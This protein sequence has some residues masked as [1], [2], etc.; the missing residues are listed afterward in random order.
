MREVIR[1][2]LGV[3]YG[4]PTIDGY[5]GG[6]LPLKS[7]ADFKTLLIGSEP[8]VPH[9]TLA[10]QAPARPNAPLLAAL[11]VRYLLLDGRSGAPG[12]GWALREAVVSAAW[13]YENA[14]FA[15]RAFVVTDVRA[16]PDPQRALALLSGLDLR[17]TAVVERPVA[18]LAAPGSGATFPPA[19]SARILRYSAGA[20]EVSVDG[21]G[22]LLMTE[23]FYPGWRAAVDDRAAPIVRADL[24]FRG[25]PV[26][27]GTHRVRVWYDPASV[28]L[29]F[30]LSALGLATNAWALWL[31]RR[32]R[33]T[34]P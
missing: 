11:G 33:R 14:D 6:L 17:R 31:R 25:V 23:T 12:P 18:D 16:E 7:Y 15:P 9:L 10:P 26:P 20:L 3:V 4:L 2:N 34:T 30:G 8:P 13:L 32:A 28:K 19:T 27:A 24:L 1:P 29:G 21:P 22:L 5:D